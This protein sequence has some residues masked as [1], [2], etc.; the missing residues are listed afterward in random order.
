MINFQKWTS[1]ILSSIFKSGQIDQL[2]KVDLV[3]FIVNFQRWTNWSTFKGGPGGF[4]CQFSKVDELINFRKWTWWILLSIFKSGQVDQLSKVDFVRKFEKLRVDG[5]I[6]NLLM[7]SENWKKT[8]L[9]I[10]ATIHMNSP[11]MSL[12]FW[13]QGLCFQWNEIEDK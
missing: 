1:W 13:Q 3:D 7:Q 5:L 8:P 11:S 2:S 10:Q 6:K 9:L 4:N 12:G